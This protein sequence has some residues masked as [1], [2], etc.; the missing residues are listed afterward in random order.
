ML[1]GLAALQA[2][3]LGD[4]KVC[5][6][7]L[8][9]PADLSHPCF[10]GA[11]LRRLHT[12][13]PDNAGGGPMA[14]HGTHVASMLFGQPASPV[15]G[16]APHC[17]GLIVPVFRDDQEGRLS[18][19][20]LA[21]AIEQSVQEGAHIISISGGERSTDGQADG[22]LE[23]ALRLCADNNV[24]VVAAV[25]NDGCACTQ[26]PAAL[27]SVLAAGA[28]GVDGQPLDMSNWGNAYRSNGVLAPGEDITGAAPG[29]GTASLT[30]TSFATPV[31]AGVAALLLSLQVKLGMPIDPGGVGQTILET[32]VPCEPPSDPACR[33]YLAGALNVARAS[34]AIKEGAETTVTNRDTVEMPVPAADVGSSQAATSSEPPAAASSGE[35][36]VGI[37]AACGESRSGSGAPGVDAR[38]PATALPVPAGPG[39]SPAPIIPNQA[40]VS[41]VRPSSGDCGCENDAQGLIFAIGTVGFDFGTEARRDSFR[42]LMPSV[43]VGEGSDETQIPPNPY[44]VVQMSDYLDNDPSESSQLIWT[45]SLDLNPIYALEARPSY[46][47]AV[48]G[49]LRIALRS[50]A[51]PPDDSA[52]ISRVSIPGVLTSRTRR[53]FSGQTVPVVEVQSRGLYGWEE[54]Q[55]IKEAIGQIESAMRDVSR[56]RIELVIRSFLDKLYVE[57]RNLG[58]SS[59]DRALNFA[60]TNIFQLTDFLVNDGLMAHTAIPSDADNL[61]ILD[62]ISVSK[63][64]YCRKDGD[65]QEVQLVFFDPE[66]E[67]RARRALLY[68]ID[69]SD[70]LP[71]PLAPARTY[72]ISSS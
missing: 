31:I 30:G 18:Q 56:S 50:Q 42:Q 3:T 32:A 16:I 21:R 55:L 43:T 51:L 71:V 26:V 9:G 27:P 33:R 60:A 36:D 13:V 17:Q 41:G 28:I 58:Q 12:L 70:V 39:Q 65:C 11:Q 38:T 44:D 37:A 46:A 7:V 63:S 72:L 6:A 2:E 57:L 20:D 48:Y 69:V 5:I 62:T 1:P 25:G 61:Y 10:L 34:T 54:G 24:L 67:R 40:A 29:G 52:R 4:A 59:P 14:L 66:N 47:D 22:I 15:G 49:K 53:L 35:Q 64:A 45:L 23:R 8:D 19:L 68:T